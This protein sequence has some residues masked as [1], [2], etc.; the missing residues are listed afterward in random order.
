MEK[1][2]EIVK[3]KQWELEKIVTYFFIYAFIGWLFEEILFIILYGKLEYRGFLYLPILPIYGFG[4]VFV[5]L[6]YPDKNYNILSVAVVGGL[7]CSFL[8]YV[9]SFVIDKTLHISLW[10]YSAL[11]Y[12]LNGRVSA[13][14]SIFFAICCVLIIKF[15]NPLI[16][17]KIK[18][19]KNT[20]L[21]EVI[22]SSLIAITFLDFAFSLFKY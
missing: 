7:L 9:T 5:S 11:R 1:S 19:Y 12:N 8:E 6:I 14:S 3:N 18:K 16:D 21:I 13:L 22:L 2:F 4:A 20:T 15:I 10:D 17:K